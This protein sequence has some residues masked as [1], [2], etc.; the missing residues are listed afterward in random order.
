[1]SRKVAPCLVLVVLLASCARQ[2]L[3]GSDAPGFFMGLLHGFLMVPSLIGSIWGDVRIYTF[4]NDGIW[5]DLGFVIGAAIFFG[6]V[7]RE[8]QKY[9]ATYYTAGYEEGFAAGKSDQNSN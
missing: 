5:Y 4:P 2:P 9:Y 7:G 3:S 6:S 8:S 1:M